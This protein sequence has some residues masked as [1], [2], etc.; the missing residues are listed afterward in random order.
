MRR[1]R[2]STLR[3]SCALSNWRL[4]AAWESCSFRSLSCCP[5]IA[6]LTTFVGR[7][8]RE[9]LDGYKPI[10]IDHGRVRVLWVH[11]RLPG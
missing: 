6:W 3:F 4:T 8:P 11:L 5:S 10:G 1:A 2:S 9:Q 7:E